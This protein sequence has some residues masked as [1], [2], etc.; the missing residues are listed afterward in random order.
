MS[1]HARVYLRFKAVFGG[2]TSS[3]LRRIARERAADAGDDTASTGAEAS[4]PF[5]AGRDPV[6]LGSVFADMRRTLGWQTPMAQAELI[7]AWT[8]IAGAETAAHST[9]MHVDEGTLVVQCDSTAWATQL[10]RMRDA[11]LGRIAERYPDARVDDIRFLNPG[12]PSW[13]RGR[14]SVPGRGPRDT[15]G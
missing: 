9:P 8:T 5:G 10:R 13:K 4:V 12:A 14:R 7:D 2:A 15:Y 6:A 3:Y 1:E 11:I